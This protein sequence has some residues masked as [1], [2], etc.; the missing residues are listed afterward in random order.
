MTRFFLL[1]RYMKFIIGSMSTRKIKVAEKV[2]RQLFL[3]DSA[4]S[5]DGY[6]STSGVPETPYD[7]QTFDGSRNRAHDANIHIPGADYYIGMES[8][9]IERYGHI[10]E[11]AWCTIITSNSKEYYGYSSGL[12]VPD[13]V[14]QK[15]D[16]LGIQH[17]E[18]M[19][20]LEK[21]HGKLPNDTW[22]NYS[23]G[24]L[25]RAVSL[26]EA[27]RNALIQIVA[28]EISFFKKI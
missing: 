19:T 4:I 3:N 20:I 11:E 18:V 12:K 21:E 16:A 25:V 7:V 14:L 17:N 5:I 13:Y 27:I 10:Y 26:E 15:M 23:G 22:G 6:A 8:G 2:I 9:L 1:T 24:M 28:P